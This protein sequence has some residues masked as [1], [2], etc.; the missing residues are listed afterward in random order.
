MLQELDL[1]N[2]AQENVMLAKYKVSWLDIYGLFCWLNV[3]FYAQPPIV[4]PTIYIKCKIITCLVQSP[5]DM[6]SKI[7]LMDILK[8]EVF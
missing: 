2:H 8:D 6:K 5:G 3:E 4:K 1:N 7:F